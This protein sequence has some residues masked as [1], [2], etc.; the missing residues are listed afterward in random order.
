MQQ[1]PVEL[2]TLTGKAQA[3]IRN[4]DTVSRTFQ[5]IYAI[6]ETVSGVSAITHVDVKEVTLEAGSEMLVE[7]TEKLFPAIS[8]TA[9]CK[10]FVWDDKQQP[11]ALLT[12]DKINIQATYH[13]DGSVTYANGLI[14]MNDKNIQYQGR[15]K[16]QANGSF[17]GYFESGLEFDF[18][19]TS[20]SVALEDTCRILYSIDGGGLQRNVTA[21]GTV[22]LATGL[23]EGAHSVKFYSEYQ[24]SFPKIRNFKINDGA[25]TKPK[26]KKPAMEFIGDSISV[27]YIGAGLVNSLGSSFSFKTPELLGF[28]HNTVAFGGIAMV[29]GSGGPDNTGMV[30]RYFKL[31]EY[32][33]GEANVS[34][35]DTTKYVP[36]Y[37]VIN[38]GTNDPSTGESASKFKPAYISFLENIRACYPNAVVFA[39]S[40][41]N[42]A[43]KNEIA[44]AV[45]LRNTAGDNKVIYID[46]TGWVNIATETT[47]GTHPTIEAQN[48]ISN[49]LMTS[50]QN[51]INQQH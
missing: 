29:A 38:L 39:M 19:G 46:T 26:A 35:W 44:E 2:S 31:S 25:D 23:S 12:S 50:I 28:S 11:Y 41:F 3:Y 21:S 9:I 13:A 34:T 20:I 7:S 24:Q 49:N 32:T 16:E 51:Y 6:Y 48:K 42:S 8:N 14:P 17:Y 4:N 47:D 37:V 36:D 40:P 30:S 10:I 43:H 45:S 22:V 1:K 5:L 15:W 33:P 27:G 18:T